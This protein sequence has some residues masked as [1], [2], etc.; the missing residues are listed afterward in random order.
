[1]KI[2]ICG[3]IKSSNLGEQ[4]ISKSLAWLIKDELNNQGYTGNVEFIEVDI[5]ATN[6]VVVECGNIVQSRLKNLYSY[7]L[8]GIPADILHFKLK[9]VAD[10]FN[11][12]KNKNRIYRF[13]HFMWKHCR[14]LGKRFEKYYEFKFKNVDFIAIDGAGL[15]EYSYNSYQESL[16]LICEYAERKSIPVIFNAIG[17][18]GEFNPSDFRCQVLMSAFRHDCVKFVSARDSKESVQACVGEKFNVRLLADAAFCVEEAFGIKA[19]S[20]KNKIGIGL[21]RGDAFLS[22]S[23]GFSENDWIDLFVNIALLLNKHGYDYEFFTNGMDY[24]YNI[25]LKVID[26][27]GENNNKLVTRPIEPMALLNTISSYEGI[28][29]CRMHSSIAAFSLGIPS[30]ILSW[31]DKVDKYME[32]VG[33][34][35]RA[36][37]RSDFNSEYIVQ[38][39]EKT[40]L[41]GISEEKRIKMKNLARESVKSYIPY[42][43]DIK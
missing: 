8:W 40:L 17:R 29:T 37:S 16:A 42:I 4:F 30:I 38:I 20:N 5:Q 41:E 22:Y 34:P 14:N 26:R 32:I 13:R 39:L 12:I 43:K 36:I 21:I 18:A 6:D 19:N 1:M 31:N 28:I 27:L 35:E 33:Y 23:N 3:L 24:D 7:T 15:L 2:A 11:S 10:Q 25:G 9:G